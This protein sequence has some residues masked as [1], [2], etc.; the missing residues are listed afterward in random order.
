MAHCPT[1]DYDLS[2]L[3]GVP[4]AAGEPFGA[5]VRCPECGRDFPAGTLLLSGSAFVAALQPATRRA[6]VIAMIVSVAPAAWC[7]FQ[8]IEGLIDLMTG[9]GVWWAN[10]LRISLLAIVGVLAAR[11]IRLWRR[12]EG[13]QGAPIAGRDMAWEVRPGSLET[14]MRGDESR[15]SAG[16]RFTVDRLR[17]VVAHAA[18]EVPLAAGERPNNVVLLEAYFWVSDFRGRRS[19]LQSMSIFVDAG[20][21]RAELP[22]GRRSASLAAGH[23]LAARV[24]ETMRAPVG[25]AEAVAGSPAA[26]VDVAPSGADVATDPRAITVTGSPRVIKQLQRGLVVGGL[27]GIVVWLVL[28]G[29]ATAIA[30]LGGFM[31]PGNAGGVFTAILAVT[32]PASIGVGWLL[33]RAHRAR[34]AEVATWTAVPGELR[35]DTTDGR[36]PGAAVRGRTHPAPRLHEVAA[37]AHDGRPMLVARTRGGRTIARLDANLST[38]EA[39]LLAQRMTLLIWEGRS[40]PT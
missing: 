20:G 8:G 22:S 38:G 23:A 26:A 7:A 11:T 40:A 10:V 16:K 13:G 25:A 21:E 14:F 4:H 3:P 19:D 9:R 5:P 18:P 36:R 34:A 24:A 27:A 30:V 32:I 29:A 33:W 37:V 31:V 15:V 39:E 6:R 12:A 28:T 1:C 35:I 2:S 17:N